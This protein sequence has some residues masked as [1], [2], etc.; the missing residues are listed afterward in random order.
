MFENSTVCLIVNAKCL[1]LVQGVAL[2]TV[3]LVGLY[4]VRGCLDGHKSSDLYLAGIIVHACSFWVG[5][6]VSLLRRV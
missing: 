1:T 4:R 2:L 3:W 5:V 6:D